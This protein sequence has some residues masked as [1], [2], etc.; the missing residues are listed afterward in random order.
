MTFTISSEHMVHSRTKP[1]RLFAA[2]T[3]TRRQVQSLEKIAGIVR[4]R[5]QRQKRDQKLA[6]IKRLLSQHF[7]AEW[8][9]FL[10][11]L[12]SGDGPV[13]EILYSIFTFGPFHNIHLECL[14]SWRAVS[15]STFCAMTGKV[16]RSSR[17]E[18]GES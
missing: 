10:E 2:K 1:N 6:G 13:R 14:D 11:E 17:L 18:S 3:Q 8:P 5:S 16:T 15:F 4:K 9:S 7:L 12:S